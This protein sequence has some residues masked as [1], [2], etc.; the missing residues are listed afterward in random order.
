MNRFRY[1][2]LLALVIASAASLSATTVV[3]PT[4]EQLIEKTPII[5]IGRVLASDAIEAGGGI[6]TATEV[7]VEKR[8]KGTTAETVTIRELGGSVGERA[9][10]VFGTPHF[11]VG[12]RV[13]LFLAPSP[14][15][16]YRT[17]DMFI[18]KFTERRGQDGTPFWYRGNRDGVQVLNRHFQ[19]AEFPSVQRKRDQFETFIE[20]RVA[21][22][23]A[24]AGYQVSN[25]IIDETGGSSSAEDGRISA[26]FTLISEPTIYRWSSFDSSTTAQWLSVSSQPGY[27]GGGVNEAKAGIAA[28]T[29]FSGAKILYA[30]KGA[31]SSTPGGMDRS[32]GINEII[33][34]DV[35]DDIDGSYSSRSGGVVGVGGFNK[36]SSGGS[37]TAPFAADGTHTA[38]TYTTY[39]IT[40]ANLV[41]QDGVTPANGISSGVLAEILAHEFGHTLGFGHSDDTGALMYK[42]VTGGGASLK[43]DD[44][45]AA[46]WL[47]P[48][49][50]S[51]GT[52]PTLPAA[53]SSLAAAVVDTSS[54]RLTWKDNASDESS[55]KLYVAAGSGA[56]AMAG[57][58]GANVT[59]V[60]VGSLAAG[61]TYRFYV[62]AVNGAGESSASNIAQ[63]T[64]PSSVTLPSAP[65]NLSGTALSASQARL[66]WSDLASNEV[67]Q[68]IYRA[69][70][71]GSY[72]RVATLGAG[73]TSAEVSGLSAGMTYSFYVTASNSAGESGPSNVAK[74][75]TAALAPALVASFS[76]SP[77]SPSTATDI[78]FTDTSTGGPVSWSWNFGDGTA[79]TAARP[80][81]RYANPGTYTVTLRVTNATS[82]S[83]AS[84]SIPVTS[85]APATPSVSAEFDL[86]PVSP[87]AG[88]AVSFTDRSSGSPTSWKWS[89]GDGGVSTSRNPTH[90]YAVAGT[91]DVTLT[92]TSA[93]SSSV[94]TRRITVAAE[95]R[96]RSV[97]PVAAQTSGAGST[98][99]R[100]ELSIFNAGTRGATV[101]LRF[102]PSPGGTVQSRTITIGSGATITAPNALRDLFGID[103][104]SGAMMIE[105][106]DY[107][108]TPDLKVAS[109]TFTGGSSGTYGQFVPDQ[110]S[111]DEA[112]TLYLTGMASGATFRTNIGL[113]N[114]SDGWNGVTITLRDSRGVSFG[115]TQVNLPPRTF[116]QSALTAMFPSLAGRDLSGM[117]AHLVSSAASGWHAYASVVDNRSQDPVYIR[118]VPSVAVRDQVIPA[119][120]RTAGA[121][122]TY[123]KSDVSLHNPTGAAVNVSMYYLA[124]GADNMNAVP[125]V[126]SVP[127]GHTVSVGD[128]LAS[129]GIA[130]GSGALRLTNPNGTIV[131]SSRTY[132]SRADGGTYG[133]S[134]DPARTPSFS[135]SS[136][137]TGLKSN[138]G[139]RTNL[140]MVNLGSSPITAVLTLHRADGSAAGTARVG[141]APRSQA[142]ASLASL[143]PGVDVSS[144]GNFTVR[145][146]SEGGSTLFT[147]GSVVDNTSGDP[148]FIGGE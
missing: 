102:L 148:I 137:V 9:A 63:V 96:F 57:S 108:G 74:I 8:L 28:W 140:G 115:Q 88:A 84:R 50:S 105:S 47:Y 36:V 85:G 129:F 131:A 38:K 128:V 134:I 72:S 78:T 6:H 39:A 3:L 111:A 23:P 94:K 22:R 19:Q 51:G 144:L 17:R 87:T 69:T 46:R 86:S 48:S 24:A 118:A 32:N 2:G 100:T 66:Q 124:A 5:V 12:E 15:G 70:G 145:A 68:H 147:Y 25:P 77:V 59:A 139:Y 73:V 93:S 34:N 14:L 143:Y 31:S 53:P 107:A 16:G 82:S 113:A 109:R 1:S 26:N 89:F 79:S 29:S 45:V 43:A 95:P 33:F 7:L 83:T 99:W 55:Q 56:F 52:S 130:S 141:L 92:A 125:R 58:L 146:R 65:A 114:A 40:E 123:W 132:T 61:S 71:T 80:V 30:Y 20:E 37:W 117:S 41:I 122:G 42:S 126:V 13:L 11:E 81:K 104:G 116:Q 103:S 60:N 64:T 21:G 10:V 101:D 49:G 112:T 110:R 62:T 27:T 127:A 76:F 54:V 136:V 119:V 4:D 75:T 91:Y 135:A 98:Y 142:Q 133:Q 121:G 106:V 35:T 18:G 90:V 120:G 97:L 44:Q 138:S 67:S